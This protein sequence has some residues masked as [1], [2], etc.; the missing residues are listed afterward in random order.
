MFAV[1]MVGTPGFT[2]LLVFILP[3]VVE[4]KLKDV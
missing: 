3:E 1:Q 2:L 4:A